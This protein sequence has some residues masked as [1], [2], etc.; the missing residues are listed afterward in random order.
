MHV[1]PR[2][3]GWQ[4]KVRPAFPRSLTASTFLLAAM[5]PNRPDQ[6]NSTLTVDR[7]KLYI[8]NENATTILFEIYPSAILA[9]TTCCGR[10]AIPYN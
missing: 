2:R 7:S 10:Q 3:C 4:I 1:G 6:P 5:V 9:S 8:H